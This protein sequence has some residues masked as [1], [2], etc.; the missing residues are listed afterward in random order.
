MEIL[1]KYKVQILFIFFV[2]GFIYILNYEVDPDASCKHQLN[3]ITKLGANGKV[4]EK[5]IDVKNHNAQ[6]IYV[7]NAN[8]SLTRFFFDL[9]RSHLY[10]SLKVEYLFKKNVEERKVYYGKKSL[11]NI[12]VIDYNC[13]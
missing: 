5:Y 3:E 8:G 4:I 10:D 12:A 11:N 7:R 2:C 6:I 1:V 9:D 13:D